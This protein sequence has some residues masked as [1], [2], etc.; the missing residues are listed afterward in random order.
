MGDKTLSRGALT[1]LVI[2]RRFMRIPVM[3]AWLLLPAGTLAYWQAWLYLSILLMPMLAVLAYL[4]KH[5]PALLERR[6]RTREKATQQRRIVRISILIVALAFLIPGFDQRF[7]WSRVPVALVIVADLLVLLGYG[8]FFLVLRENSYAS[9]VVEVQQGQKVI[10]TGPYAVVRHP[11]YLA[12]LLMGLLSPLALGSYWA[13]I[14]MA[15]VVPVLVMRI[16]NEE[17]MLE[18]GLA[19]YRDYQQDVRFRLIPGIW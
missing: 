16:R 8:L 5:D 9:R 13:M 2:S 15:F 3:L 6:M 7:G 17:A 11:M 1:R 18:T 19:G 4:L 10:T 12:V 14:P